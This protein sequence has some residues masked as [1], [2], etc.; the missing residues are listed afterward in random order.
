MSKFKDYSADQ[1]AA[2]LKQ[3]EEFENKYKP[4]ATTI[5]WRKWCTDPEYRKREWQLRQNVAK[6]IGANTNINYFTKN[7]TI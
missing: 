1:I 6:S 4:S 2:K 5:G 7:T 3:V